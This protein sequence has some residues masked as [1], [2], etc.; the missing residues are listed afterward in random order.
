MSFNLI[1][2]RLTFNSISPTY[3]VL[4]NDTAP[5]CVTLELPWKNNAIDVSC[6]PPGVYPVVPNTPQ[7]PWRLCNVPNRT[8]I[9]IHVANTTADILGCIGLGFQFGTN[10]ILHSVDAVNYLKTIVPANWS[11][12]I[13]NPMEG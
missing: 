3:G 1:L 7:K 5:L 4:L 8:E 13:V 6:I 2:R 9:D 11:L 10:C 12:T